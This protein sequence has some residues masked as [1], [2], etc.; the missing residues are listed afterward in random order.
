MLI[1][2]LQKLTLL[3]W[4]GKVACTVFTGGCNLR[5][6]YCH[7]AGLVLRPN[8]QPVLDPQEVFDLLEKRKGIIDGVCVT[9]GEPLI[10][11]D[12]SDFLRSLRQYGVAVKLDT[13]G[14]FP[15][16]LKM[17]IGEGLVDYIAMDI[18]GD[19]GRYGELTG[20]P[21]L[22]IE[23]VKRSVRLLM[24]GDIPYEFRTT[25]AAETHSPDDFHKIG[26]W[27]QGAKAYY[28]QGYRD[29]G[30]TVG[31]PLTSPTP[32][33]ARAILKVLQLYVPVAELR[34]ID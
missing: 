8:E 15:D 12:I 32:A 7:N 26:Q 9:G 10:Q 13:N 28:I 27:I 18:K 1:C 29:S 31:A 25:I 11:P 33:E 14:F 21:D 20:V 16:K 22:D 5:C 17:L 24:D 3:D 6:P 2:G 4:P 19:P 34:G 23:P 30:D